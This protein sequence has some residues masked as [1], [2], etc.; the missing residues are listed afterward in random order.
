M[1]LSSAVMFVN[2]AYAMHT[3]TPPSPPP[4]A[5][6]TASGAKSTGDPH[7]SL[8]HGGKADF[9]GKDATTYAFL[10]APGI[11]VNVGVQ[12]SN[13]TLNKQRL[14][15]HGSFFTSV[16]INVNNALKVSLD[17]SR[18]ND[19]N[20]AWNMLEGTCGGARV[21]L[22][23]H[24]EHA[25]ATASIVTQYSSTV[26]TAMGWS[27]T[28]TSQPVYDRVGWG[29]PRHRLDVHIVRDADS[30]TSCI[31]G[32]IGQSFAQE[33]RDGK[34]DVYPH[35]GEMTTSAM[36]EG[37]IDG[38]PDDYVVP[39]GY[40]TD[41]KFTMFQPTPSAMEA[42]GHKATFKSSSAFTFSSSL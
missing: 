10:S 34:L 15:V 18:V 6:Q 9:R 31:H 41:F 30:H 23:P 5:T 24:S 13:F 4:P 8:A 39:H 19:R 32:I 14:L 22:G 2:A 37:A 11:A 21:V 36:G 1:S 29:G 7:L 38:V 42:C 3:G 20:Y 25:C 28:A 26:V 35:S 33:R 17:A 40:D 27:V 12:L 16:Y